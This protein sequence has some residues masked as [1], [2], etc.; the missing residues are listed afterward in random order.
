[1]DTVTAMYAAAVAGY[2]IIVVRLI[3]ERFWPKDDN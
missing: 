2:L 3:G 1:M